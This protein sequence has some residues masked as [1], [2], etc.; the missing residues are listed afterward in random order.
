M[1]IYILWPSLILIGQ[2]LQML[3][4]KQ[5]QIWQFSNSRAYN[6]ESCALISSIIEIIQDLMVIYTLTKFGADWLIF[7]D[8]RV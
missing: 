8:V 4:C 5:S 2:Y 6:S 7:V 3:E 1:G